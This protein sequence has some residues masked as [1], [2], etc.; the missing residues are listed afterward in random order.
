MSWY[1]AYTCQTFVNAGNLHFLQMAG[2]PLQVNFSWP[3][4][5]LG[6]LFLH[7][8][9]VSIWAESGTANVCTLD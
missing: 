9:H 3:F 4:S 1:Q 5:L 8:F 7:Q 6:I 2:I